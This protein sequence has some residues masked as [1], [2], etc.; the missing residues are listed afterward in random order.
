MQAG[1]TVNFEMDGIDVEY[2]KDYDSF[3]QTGSDY[4]FNNVVFK[5]LKVTGFYEIVDTRAYESVKFSNVTKDNKKGRAKTYLINS[6]TLTVDDVIDADSIIEYS[7]RE[8]TKIGVQ[9]QLR[10]KKFKH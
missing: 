10:K 6:S 3:W 1:Y 7:D 5:N 8:G 4:R 2:I 9:L